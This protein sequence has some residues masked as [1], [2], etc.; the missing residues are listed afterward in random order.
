MVLYLRRI[1]RDMGLAEDVAQES[2]LKAYQA[3]SRWK[4]TGTFAGWLYT[5]ARNTA[6]KRLSRLSRWRRIPTN[7]SAQ[8][9]ET[10]DHPAL[11]AELGDRV[12]QALDALPE[13]VREAVLLR[14]VAGRSF[15]EIAE[16][17]GAPLSTVADRVYG[18]LLAM[19]PLLERTGWDCPA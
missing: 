13:A 5:I 14:V 18:G 15:A 6:L 12:G 8:T 2:F 17:T 16:V 11:M 7:P 10:P 1:L 19:R 9:R 3:S 4:P